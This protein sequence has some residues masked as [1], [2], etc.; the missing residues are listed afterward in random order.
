M[1]YCYVVVRRNSGM[2][3]MVVAV[4]TSRSS[5]EGYIE[6][7]KGTALG[8]HLDLFGDELVVLTRELRD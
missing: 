4:Y 6:R 5:A 3:D 2:P 7:V 8:E 1:Y